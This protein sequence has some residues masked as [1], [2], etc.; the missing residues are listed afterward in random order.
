L[1]PAHIIHTFK[2]LSIFG[3][4][5]VEFPLIT[6]GNIGSGYSLGCRYTAHKFCQMKYSNTALLRGTKSLAV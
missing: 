2:D 5:I 1:K 4:D 3:G 6:E